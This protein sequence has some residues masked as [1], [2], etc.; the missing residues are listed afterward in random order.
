[1]KNLSLLLNAILI[2]AISILYYFHFSNPQQSLVA[3]DNTPTLQVAQPKDI[4]NSSIVYINADSLFENYAYVQ[5]LKQEAEIKHAQ[6]EAE[7]NTKA[8]K[9][10][11]DYAIYQQKLGQALITPEQAKAT[12]ENLLKRKNE[13]D[14][15]EQ[16]QAALLED[17]QKKNIIVQKRINEFLTAYNKKTGYKFVLTYTAN[18]GSVLFANDSL[19]ITKDV[20]AGLNAIYKQKK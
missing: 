14:Q 19:D 7:F 10:Q 8:K 15:M 1:M 13:L 12:E 9:L 11:E 2:I 4:K 16:R 20:V 17:T 3:T 5:E 6:L 18:G